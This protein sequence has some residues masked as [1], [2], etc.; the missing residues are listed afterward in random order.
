[1]QN[2]TIYDINKSTKTYSLKSTVNNGTD[3]KFGQRLAMSADAEFIAVGGESF[4][5]GIFVYKWN[6]ISYGFLQKIGREGCGM[7]P[8]A[9]S[10]AFSYD[11]STLVIG[12]PLCERNS[13]SYGAVHVYTRTSMGLFKQRDVI[14]PTDAPQFFGYSIAVTANG[15]TIVVGSDSVGFTVQV[16]DWD[17]E[18]TQRGSSLRGGHSVSVDISDDGNNILIGSKEYS[19]GGALNNGRVAYYRW[20]K[21]EQ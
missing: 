2:V 21:V 19:E 20:E 8:S 10:M 14:K 11:G 17:T 7:Q 1:M 6:G 16:F 9:V 5:E 3:P 4:Q 18:W 13:T 12:D 15:G